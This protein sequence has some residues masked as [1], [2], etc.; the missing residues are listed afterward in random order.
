[1]HQEGRLAEAEAM[2]RKVIAANPRD[3][4]SLINLGLITFQ[5]HRLEEAARWFRQATRIMPDH[6]DAHI[7][8]GAVCR[9]LGR[10][11]EAVES[12]HRAL[13]L[14]P[15]S[16]LAHTILGQVL[17]SQERLDE[18]IGHFR[19]A[20]AQEPASLQAGFQ[21]A[22]TLTEQG[23][24]AAAIPLLVEVLRQSSEMP[25]AWN[26]LGLACDQL[27]QTEDAAT[28]YTTALRLLP[29]FWV[30]H[31]NLG[32][33]RQRQGRLAEAAE[34]CREALRLQ[35]NLSPAHIRLGQVQIGL[36]Q[37]PEAMA[38]FRRA[39]LLTPEQPDA[40]DGLGN[41]LQALGRHDEAVDAYARA[42]KSRP[43]TV[44]T[45]L[46]LGQALQGRVRLDEAI[47]VFAEA[48]RVA[49]GLL[50]G[51]LQLISAKLYAADW[52]DLAQCERRVLEGV[53]S[54]AG[55]ASPFIFLM[56]DSTAE[57]QLASAR[58]WAD[59]RSAGI[60]EMQPPVPHTGERIRIGYL[61]TDFRRHATAFL[62]TGLFE[63]HDRSRFETFAYSIGPDDGS[64]DRRRLEAAF[65]GFVDLNA[66]SHEQA[67]GRIRADRIDILVDLKGYTGGSR[68]EIM[69]YRPAPIQVNYL[70]YP[71]TMG[72]GFIDY[73][74]VDPVIVPPA[75]APF[76][77]EKLVHLPHSYQP[78]MHRPIGQA[79]DT[80]ADHDL[81]DA[82][83]VF[84][85]FNQAYKITPPVF[86][87]WMRLLHDVPDSVLWLLN[88]NRFATG[89]LQREAAARGIDPSRLI[90]GPVL[91]P[92]DHLG[93]LRHADLCL[94]TQPYCAHTTASDALWAGV[95]LISCMG[96]TFVSRV[97]GSLLS[98]MGLGDLVTETWPEYE[99]L[100]LRLAVD[101][102]GLA[103]VRQRVRDGRTSSPLFNAALMTR[104]VEAAFSEMWQRHCRGAVPDAFAV[105]PLG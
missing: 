41:A 71:G 89:N 62:M 53:H 23:Q 43:G 45:L 64:E 88:W 28:H 29:T 2:Y 4:G 38:S 8:L 73:I 1:M 93:R 81:P 37:L 40:L 78:N 75:M 12:L 63:C 84:C 83:F 91:A 54:G 105:A 95:P 34:H 69:A 56:V 102:A 9:A 72:A 90:F 21:L 48:V 32:G 77:S 16:A 31:Y 100:A 68:P 15:E 86:D 92:A 3:A 27:G 82:A 85:C 76:F 58:Q 59:G 60:V 97:S 30:A 39:L 19:V 70:G 55:K 44:Q 50:T 101:R 94:D 14:Q 104:H 22:A 51:W 7:N 99:A 35:P 65:D 98:A 13:I 57:Q 80:R 61:S 24:P 103:T 87:V 46:N 33:A 6:V 47:E 26:E 74:M 25:D 67:A 79:A 52:S 11:E 49:P 17:R 96:E 10:P 18:A 20:L 36:G 66:L 42:I 5:S